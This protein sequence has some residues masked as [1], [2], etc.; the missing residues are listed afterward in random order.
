[1]KNYVLPHQH[2]EKE[3]LQ[4]IQTELEHIEKFQIVADIFKQLGDTTRIRIFWLLYHCEECVVNISAMLDM[5]SPAISHHLRPL[6]NSGFIVSRREGKEMYYRAA[7]TEQ[8]R[9]LHIM[10]EQVMDIVCPK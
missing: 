10:I 8:C 1:M 4:Y 9:L 5:S 3:N 2:G 7:D 6:K